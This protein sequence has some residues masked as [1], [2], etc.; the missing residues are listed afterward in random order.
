[1]SS[2]LT[3]TLTYGRSLP[4]SNSFAPSPGCRR[5]RSSSAAFT[6]P[7][8]TS[9]SDWPP[10]CSRIGVGICTLITMS[11]PEED[12]P[13]RHKGH[14]EDRNPEFCVLDLCFCLLCALCVFV[15]NP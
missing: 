12:S 3:N 5:T 15:V 11:S 6:V 13:Q 10:A 4:L 2:S 9:T 7:P 14:K 8:D 1:M